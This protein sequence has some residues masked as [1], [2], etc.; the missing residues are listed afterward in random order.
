VALPR[1][2]ELASLSWPDAKKLLSGV[3][4]VLIP[5]GSIEQHGPHLP[6]STDTDIAREVCSRASAL[7]QVPFTPAI[8][9]GFSIEHQSFSGTLTLSPETFLSLVR[10]VSASLRSHGFRKIV[11][12]NAHGGNTGLLRAVI[13]EVRMRYNALPYLV[14]I[15]EIGRELSREILEKPS[16]LGHGDEFET[17]I[18]LSI[19]PSRVRM[20]TLSQLRRQLPPVSELGAGLRRGWRTEDYS[21]LGIIGDPRGAS[22]EKGKRLL[23]AIVSNLAR[24]LHRIKVER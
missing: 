20:K 3:D 1:P 5:V 10:E 7:S 9:F 23:D 2:I 21:R 14:S 13:Q 8:A 19:D 4:T 17:S 16:P 22:A 24:H 18:M 15:W 12:V 6:L 11:Y